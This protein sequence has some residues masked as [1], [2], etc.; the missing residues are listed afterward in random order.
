MAN[1]VELA[2]EQRRALDRLR[3]LAERL[4]L[5]LAGGTALGFHLGHWLVEHVRDALL[6]RIRVPVPG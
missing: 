5:Y 6:S 3:P 4:G 2:E 1:P